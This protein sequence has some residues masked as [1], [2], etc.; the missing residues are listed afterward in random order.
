MHSR[1]NGSEVSRYDT[2]KQ[3]EKTTGKTPPE[4]QNAPTLRFEHEYVWTAY[5]SL[6]QFTYQEINAYSQTTGIL[7]QGW[8]VNAII[9][10]SKNI[11]VQ[12]WPPK[13]RS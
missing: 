8:E 6:S 2:L 13:S 5:T 1:P 3:V 12:S 10:L 7:L 9:T 4:L 11:E